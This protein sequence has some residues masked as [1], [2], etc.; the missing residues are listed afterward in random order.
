MYKATKN[1]IKNRQHFSQ[2]PIKQVFVEHKGGGIAND[3][4]KNSINAIDE[5][6]GISVVSGWL[7]W[8][9]DLK[10]NKTV[11]NQHYWNANKSGRYF[12]TTPLALPSSE[13]EYVIDMK[14]AIYGQ[15]NS[16][17]I[18]S[19]VCYSLLCSDEEY[20]AYEALDGKTVKHKIENLSEQNIFKFK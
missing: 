20:E 7:V 2:Y 5:P 18:R 9:Y 13:F 10:S 6:A 15:E 16:E 12:D 14:L 17:K 3:C 11:I 1:L 4:F 8:K 19:S